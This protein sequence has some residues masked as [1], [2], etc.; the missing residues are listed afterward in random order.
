[1]RKNI[2]IIGG[3]A[4][5]FFA[6]IHAAK[7]NPNA[8]I[9]ILEALKRPLTKVLISG[10]GRCNVTNHTLDN[11]ELIK[12]YPRGSKELR[13]AFS[14]FS[15]TDTIAFFES[16]GVPLHVEADKRMFPR[17]NCSATIADCLT[18][19]AQSLGVTLETNVKIT[20]SSFEND[21]FTISTRSGEQRHADVLILCAGGSPQS[22]DLARQLGHT[23]VDP[24]PSLFTFKIKDP[25]IDE[26]QGI[27]FPEA[28][29]RLRCHNKTFTQ[30]GPL[31]I[32]HW[33]LSG[34]A[35]IILSAHAARE[36]HASR[37]EGNLQVNFLPESERG[38]VQDILMDWKQRH[39]KKQLA[40]SSPFSVPKR[41]W[42][43]TLS[44]AGISDTQQFHDCSKA[45][46]HKLQ[47]LL[48]HHQLN[49]RGKGQFKDE[50]VTAGGVLLKEV[51]FKT[52]RSKCNPNLYLAGEV[53]NIDGVTGG[54]NFQSAWTTGWIAG[55]NC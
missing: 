30:Q 26:L 48:E 32:T 29:L 45:Q 7:H 42:L 19:T 21:T 28:S 24:V 22:F 44:V 8:S 38:R 5:G 27:S 40:S 1:M 54:F 34:P 25:L 15:V 3:G 46:I 9:R 10:G 14:R 49:V 4:A 50:F 16:H 39:G 20:S 13:G 55:N 37:Y 6:A 2:I 11:T 53:L 43:R 52:M 17:S 41:F 33:G 18:D 47:T 31:L 36:L 12:H 51:D 35:A 23:I